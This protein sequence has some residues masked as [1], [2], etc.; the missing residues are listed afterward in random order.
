MIVQRDDQPCEICGA[1][2]APFGYGPPLC[3]HSMWRCGGH[4]L[5]GPVAKR[6]RSPHLLELET[7]DLIQRMVSAWIEAN[8]PTESF[9]NIC[10]HCGQ[11][12]DNLIPLGYGAR[13]PIWVHHHCSDL[14]RAELQRRA[15]AALGFDQ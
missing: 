14:F 1:S 6:Q 12:G 15:A 10:R 5:E 7:A 11:K 9:V 8:W 2:N 4:R 13:P 3:P